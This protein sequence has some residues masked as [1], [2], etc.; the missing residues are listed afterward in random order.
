MVSSAATRMRFDGGSS[1]VKIPVVETKTARRMPAASVAC[2]IVPAWPKPSEATQTS[3]SAGPSGKALRSA[4]STEA[5][6]SRSPLTACAPSPPSTAS[7]SALRASPTTWWPA[8]TAWATTLRPRKP[9]P[10]MTRSRRGAGPAASPRAD[11]PDSAD[12]LDFADRV[13]AGASP[14][15]AGPLAVVSVCFI[16]C[17]SRAGTPCARRR[18]VCSVFRGFRLFLVFLDVPRVPGGGVGVAPRRAAGRAV[19]TWATRGVSLLVVGR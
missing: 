15:P 12:C 10:P 11:R 4:R 19:G 2:T 17:P 5:G 18:R 3:A 7:A 13:G 1:V 6:S 16:G 8:R 14:R 9:L